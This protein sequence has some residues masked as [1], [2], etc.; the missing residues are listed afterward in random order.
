MARRPVAVDRLVEYIEIRIMS[1]EFPVASPLPSVRRL[2]VKFDLSYGTAYRTLEKL[3]AGGMLEKREPHGFFVADRR[4]PR[5]GSGRIIAFLEPSRYELNDSSALTHCVL[6]A[7]RKALNEAGYELEIRPLHCSM[8]S[9]EAIRA[10]GRACD[11]LL[12]LN[13]YDH[14]LAELEIAVPAVGLLMQDSFG[15]R[16]STVNLDPFDLARTAVR[17]FIRR[18]VNRVTILSSPRPIYRSRGRIFAQAWSD[19]G[20]RSDF[21]DGSSR[22]FEYRAEDGYFFTSDDRLNNASSD[23]EEQH[24]RRLEEQFAVLGADGKC[25]L[26]PDYPRFP[27]V[28]GDWAMAGRFVAAEL[29]RRLRDPQGIACNLCLC[30]RLIND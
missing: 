8:A 28:S 23:W 16:V 2:A 21:F 4:P 1:G 24:G 13:G 29:L 7:A 6:L 5:R 20:G 27:T 9:A 18:G 26:N 25:L 22:D 19:I 15:G 30:G 10:A 12:L 3:C 17:Y 14:Y 11:G